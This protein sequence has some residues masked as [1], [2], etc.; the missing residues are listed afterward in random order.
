MS[1]LLIDFSLS[2]AGLLFMFE[3]TYLICFH[4]FLDDLC[5]VI[6]AAKDVMDNLSQILIRKC[7][8]CLRS[9][10]NKV[11]LGRKSPEAVLALGEAK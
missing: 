5:S 3:V 4:L 2:P 8:V 9:K 6:S 11:T 1:N 10:H 7:S